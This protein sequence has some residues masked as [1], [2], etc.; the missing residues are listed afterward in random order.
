MVHTCTFGNYLL[1]PRWMDIIQNHNELNTEWKGYNVIMC[2]VKDA[3]TTLYC[4][5][6]GIVYNSKSQ[7][8]ILNGQT[9][10]GLIPSL[11]KSMCV[12][13]DIGQQIHNIVMT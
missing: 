13:I 10:G 5:Q 6:S 12:F 7:W 8:M 4:R 1:S 3:F 2:T 11:Q 9:V